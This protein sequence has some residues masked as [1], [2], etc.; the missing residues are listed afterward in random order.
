MFNSLVLACALTFQA[1]DCEAGRCVVVERPVRS[2]IVATTHVA[3][4]TV[5]TVVKRR[6]IARRIARRVFARRCCR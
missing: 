5:R 1:G 3:R 4:T 2:V 6:Y